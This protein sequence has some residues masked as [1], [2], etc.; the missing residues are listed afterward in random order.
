VVYDLLVDEYR[1]AIPLEAFLKN[2]GGP[3]D[4][5]L[6]E[7]GLDAFIASNLRVLIDQV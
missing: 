2:G 4:D 5:Q 3:F 6:A 1:K 7:L